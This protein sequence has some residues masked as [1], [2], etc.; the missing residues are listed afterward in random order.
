MID[1]SE[2]MLWFGEN[3][4][5]TAALTRRL[6]RHQQISL[7]QMLI[8]VARAGVEDDADWHQLISRYAAM[9]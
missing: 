1:E 9:N 5:R 4:D 2:V 6:P 8:A 3:L 7:A